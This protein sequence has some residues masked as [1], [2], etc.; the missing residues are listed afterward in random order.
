MAFVCCLEKEEP[1]VCNALCLS[2][3]GL[4]L[5]GLCRFSFFE[6]EVY[7]GLIIVEAGECSSF[8]MASTLLMAATGSDANPDLS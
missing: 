6:F 3:R 5:E 1:F 4:N 8:C 2:V 7:S